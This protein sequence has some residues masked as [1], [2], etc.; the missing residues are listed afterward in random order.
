MFVVE[1][2]QGEVWVVISDPSS[3]DAAQ[4]ELVKHESDG[5]PIRI[6][7]VEDE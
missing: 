1:Q 2:M 7:T 6:R 5:F 4:I 3:R